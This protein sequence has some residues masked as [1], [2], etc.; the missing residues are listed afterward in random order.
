MQIFVI[1]KTKSG[2]SSLAKE[3]ES[4]GYKTYEAGSW[5]REEF[6]KVNKGSS[7]E[8]SVEFKEN[9]TSYAMSKLANDFLYSFKKYEEF[10][11]KEDCSRLVISGVRNPDDFI[12]M[13][14]CDTENIVLFINSSQKHSGS[15]EEFEEGIGVIMSYLKWRKSVLEIPVL[16][17]SETAIFKEELERIGLLK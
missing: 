10:R 4:V 17:I 16:E 7:E 9:L 2:K 8:L 1:G 15:L 14:G 11:K 6:S 3:L 5:A 13:L 12:R